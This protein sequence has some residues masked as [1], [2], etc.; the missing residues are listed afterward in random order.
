MRH[1]EFFIESE[2]TATLEFAIVFPLIFFIT[3]YSLLFIFWI[4]DS[5]ITTYEAS[6]LN[7]LQSVGVNLES[8]DIVYQKL[9][10]I[11][12]VNVFM[13]ST[14]QEEIVINTDLT[15]IKTT[16]TSSKPSLTP[17]LIA[18]ILAGPGE[19]NK[20]IYQTMKATSY[21]IKESYIITTP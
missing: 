16:V 11:P 19:I 3:F 20:P 6:R 9:A 10:K 7:R 8:T 5:M 17:Y 13:E 1:L 4:S 2:G 21:R 15:L 18:L 12:T 14:V